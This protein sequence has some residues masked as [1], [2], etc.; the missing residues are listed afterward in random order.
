MNLEP[1]HGVFDCRSLLKGLMGGDAAGQYFAHRQ[2]VFFPIHWMMGMSTQRCFRKSLRSTLTRR[3]AIFVGTLG[4]DK[5][6][7]SPEVIYI[8]RCTS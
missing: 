3:P 8:Q 2:F 6:F 4:A 1:N 7:W 5:L